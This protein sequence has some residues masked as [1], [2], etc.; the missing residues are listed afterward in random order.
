MKHNRTAFLPSLLATAL[1]LTGAAQAADLVIAGRDAG[2]GDALQ[3]GVDAYEAAH[4]GTDIELLKLPYGSLYEKLVIG[5]REGD[6]SFDLVLIDDTW[7]PEFM[8]NGWLAPLN[9][10]AV[11]QDFIPS[12][13]DISRYPV[14]QG[15]LFALPVVGN[16]AMFAYRSDLMD[17]PQSWDDVFAAA[18]NLK[19]NDRAGVVFRGT[20]GNPIVTGFLPMLWAY[21]GHIVDADG[22]IALNSPATVAAIEAFVSLRDVAPTG[23]EVYNSGEVRDAIQQGKAA[24][25]IE[26]WPSWVPS[27]DD[28][29]V[30]Q[31]VG[32]VNIVPPPGQVNESTPMLGVWQLGVSANSENA[33]LAEDFLA[34]FTSADF[35]RQLTLEQGLPPTRTSVYLDDDVVAKY[36]WYPNQLDALR[37]GTARPRVQ[38]WQQLESI[39]GDYLQLALLGR[40]SPEQAAK[41]AHDRMVASR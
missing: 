8:S 25:A 41:Q 37:Q 6:S 17:Q 34:F 10:D 4:P 24:M 13:T 19:T 30:S 11:S 9:E 27:M 40:L 16:V 33:D 2:Y 18:Q 15:P 3:A 31:V 36:R 5:M 39:L 14:G 35:Q 23:V 26:V 32:K 12:L 38:D 28:P 7:A 1:T 29:A 21:G 20:Q 22:N